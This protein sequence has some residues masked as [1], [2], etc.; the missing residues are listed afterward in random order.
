MLSFNLNEFFFQQYLC[1]L[2]F[3]DHQI[4]YTAK[5]SAISV[6][7]ITWIRI[8]CHWFQSPVSS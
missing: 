5:L 1:S 7:A 6:I 3:W 4:V 2:C 8:Y